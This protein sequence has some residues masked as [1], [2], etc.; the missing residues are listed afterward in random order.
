MGKM[1]TPTEKTDSVK[2]TVF[3]DRTSENW[4][5]K[6]NA[7]KVAFCKSIDDIIDGK[8]EMHDFISKEMS[9][10]QEK[11]SRNED[12]ERNNY[13]MFTLA[14]NDKILVRMRDE[15]K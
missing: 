6:K 1:F 5:V 8:A 10:R 15:L 11:N 14:N 2:K 7:N 4:Y 9:V 3:V 13:V 12:I